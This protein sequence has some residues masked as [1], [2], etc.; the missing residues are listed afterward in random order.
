MCGLSLAALGRPFSKGK[1]AIVCAGYFALY[2]AAKGTRPVP[3]LVRPGYRLCGRVPRGDEKERPLS[4]GPGVADPATAGARGVP[5][6]V[7]DL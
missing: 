1:E 4:R 7:D 3:N 6:G 2:S 5:F